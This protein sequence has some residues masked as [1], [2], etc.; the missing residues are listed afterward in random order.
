[1]IFLVAF[2]MSSLVRVADIKNQKVLDVFQHLS[3]SSSFFWIFLLVLSDT[4]LPSCREIQRSADGWVYGGLTNPQT[5]ERFGFRELFPEL[6]FSP[7]CLS[8]VLWLRM[9]TLRLLFYTTSKTPPGKSRYPT[10]CWF[11]KLELMNC[12]FRFK[13][14]LKLTMDW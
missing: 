3:I 4:Q 13:P 9:A 12:V 7:I 8:S 11:P 1:M 5:R 6:G 2:Q 14:G 10:N